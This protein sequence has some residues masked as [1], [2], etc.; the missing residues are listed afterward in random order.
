MHAS[1]GRRSELLANRLRRPIGVVVAILLA[2]HIAG[3]AP[4]AADAVRAKKA[5]I[6][7]LKDKISRLHRQ[8]YE[9]LKEKAQSQGF[10]LYADNLSQK[11]GF[12]I[13][14]ASVWRKINGP[15]DEI[16]LL[17]M[18]TPLAE[19]HPF[20]ANGTSARSG[21]DR[22]ARELESLILSNSPVTRRYSDT[23]VRAAVWV[24]P[25]RFCMIKWGDFPDSIGPAQSRRVLITS[26]KR[27]GEVCTA[28][29]TGADADA[30]PA[31]LSMMQQV[32]AG[33]SASP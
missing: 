2:F 29:V 32:L 28:T 22:L 13:P 12:D 11:D 27:D 16:V 15:A 4:T 23:T 9:S 21:I 19:D 10:T 5:R 25:S 18:V 24:G 33:E 8:Q 20:L 17:A 1:L 3:C 6:R 31:V 7:V 14:S 26:E 30:E